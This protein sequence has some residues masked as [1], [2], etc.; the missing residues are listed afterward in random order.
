MVYAII[1]LIFAFEVLSVGKWLGVTISGVVFAL[2]KGAFWTSL[3]LFFG[4]WLGLSETFTGGNAVITAGTAFAYA[5]VLSI[6]GLL[7]TKFDE[8]R[9]DW[10]VEKK[11]YEFNGASFGDV[12]LNGSGKA[13]P[14]KFGRK[15]VGWVIDGDLTVEADTPPIGKVTRK[16]LSPVAVWTSEKIAVKKTSPDPGFVKRANEL[17]N[18]EGSTA[19]RTGGVSLTSE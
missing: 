7:L 14:V 5:V 15:P 6:A 4:K 17:I 19:T 18:P 12:K 9:L 13:Y 11:A 1:A 10:K 2:A 8:K 3:F 16:L